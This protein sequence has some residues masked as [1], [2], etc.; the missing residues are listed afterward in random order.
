L[1]RRWTN[2]RRAQVNFS[3]LWPGDSEIDELF[4]IFRSLGTPDEKMWPGV[5]ELPD[6]KS[7]FPKWPPMPVARLCPE[8]LD[9]VGLDLLK[10]F[11]VYHPGD[12]ISARASMM[13]PY[14]EDLDREMDM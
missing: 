9:A 12:R 3:P 10:Q 8:D 1:P 13:H 7:V 14:F 2:K 4:R 6:Y 11:F 5:S